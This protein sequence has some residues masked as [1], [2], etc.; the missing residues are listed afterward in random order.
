MLYM[1]INLMNEGHF[2]YVLQTVITLKRTSSCVL[3][4]ANFIME[5]CNK[6]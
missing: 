3:Y 2:I 4:G 1:S 5:K 6:T